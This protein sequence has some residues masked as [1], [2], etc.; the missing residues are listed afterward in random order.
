MLE[1]LT[2]SSVVAAGIAVSAGAAFIWAAVSDLG[3]YRIPNSS[4]LLILLL[5]PLYSLLAGGVAPL[6]PHAIVG[7]VVLVLGIPLYA[8]GLAGAGDFKLLAAAALW[9]GPQAL[10][11]LLMVMALSGGLLAAAYW[12]R[13]KFCLRTAGVAAPPEGET[14]GGGEGIATKHLPYGVAISAGALV[15]LV[16]QLQALAA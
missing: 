5:F 11:M 4:V 9:A 6:L 3:A 1:G 7:G 14:T 13:A 12:L 15:V 16:Q 8:V 2:L 10:P